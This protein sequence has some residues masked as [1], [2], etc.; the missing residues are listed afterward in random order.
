MAHTVA[1]ILVEQGGRLDPK[2]LD[3]A[4]AMHLE[5]S[6]DVF[7]GYLK[8]ILVSNSASPL[9]EATP[10]SRVSQ[11][12]FVDRWD[13]NAWAILAEDRP[14]I[15]FHAGIPFALFE[16][17]SS[18]LSRNEILGD[19]FGTNERHAGDFLPPTIDYSF[20]RKGSWPQEIPLSPQQ[21]EAL[22]REVDEIRPD[23]KHWVTWSH[24][25]QPR[26]KSG[27]RSKFAEQAYVT[28]LH[29]LFCHELGHIDRGHLELRRKQANSFAL[30]EV[31][32]EKTPAPTL[33]AFDSTVLQAL[34][35]DADSYAL[36]RGIDVYLPKERTRRLEPSLGD[37]KSGDPQC[38]RLF[39][40]S[41]GVL[42][43]FLEHQQN[44]RASAAVR[45]LFGT[46]PT[47]P[48][49]TLR[50]RASILH[51]EF[52]LGN[53][54][55]E[56]STVQEACRRAL[57]DL[58]VVAK[59]FGLKPDPLVAPNSAV[60]SVLRPLT[61][62]LT[63]LRAELVECS[64]ATRERYYREGKR[65]SLAEGRKDAEDKWRLR[66]QRLA[67]YVDGREISIPFL[68]A[69][70]PVSA[71]LENSEKW[72]EG[73]YVDNAFVYALLATS[74]DSESEAA[75]TRLDAIRARL[76]PH[77]AAFDRLIGQHG[78]ASHLADLLAETVR[79]SDIEADPRR[80]AELLEQLVALRPLEVATRLKLADSRLLLKDFAAADREY[81]EA[82][83]KARLDQ[84]RAHALVGVG[85]AAAEFGRTDEA[86]G[87]FG[88]ALAIDDTY[89]HA[90]RNLG[91]ALVRGGRPTEAI[92]HFERALELAPEDPSLWFACSCAYYAARRFPEARERT[93]KAIELAPEVEHFRQALAQLDQVLGGPSPP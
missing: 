10:P 67:I 53:A 19:L 45:R 76:G 70:S 90:L 34:E 79:Q 29:F 66:G 57:D 81:R 72:E 35:I 86:V 21:V 73:G 63:E 32:Y 33:A 42:F 49:S 12:E 17:F 82:L 22:R 15:L 13:V 18:L 38:Y 62:R 25:V 2:A 78:P 75:R 71:F 80:T 37:R 69:D 5:Q 92:P 56:S 31:A 74:R 47:H 27:D 6:T 7:Q 88:K 3:G 61:K 26:P 58:V 30:H 46:A 40:F 9:V 68:E 39:L 59:L 87:W 44:S 41:L 43:L 93:E 60:A 36:G 20:V 14:L 4:A 52:L 89:V 77:A 1:D 91:I 24:Y 54:G 51:A 64:A 8:P 83:S 50:I 23:A 65:V 28:A 16:L 55:L 48:S 85:N 84:E 11:F